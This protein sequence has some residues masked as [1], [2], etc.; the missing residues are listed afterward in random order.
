MKEFD[1]LLNHICNLKTNISI[2]LDSFTLNKDANGSTD[3]L[4]VFLLYWLARI[5]FLD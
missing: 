2:G 3:M 1:R 5:L 4:D